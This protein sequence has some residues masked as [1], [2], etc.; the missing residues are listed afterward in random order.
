L[1][2]GLGRGASCGWRLRL[3]LL[4]LLLLRRLLLLLLLLLRLPLRLRLLLPPS[5]LVLLLA[6]GTKAAGPSIGTAAL[7]AAATA[8]PT[9]RLRSRSHSCNVLLDEILLLGHQHGGIGFR[10]GEEAMR[11]LTR[12]DR[13]AGHL[14]E[15]IA[16]RSSDMLAKVFEQHLR[17]I[18]GNELEL[19]HV[20]DVFRI[21]TITGIEPI[22]KKVQQM[23]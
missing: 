1:T 19:V 2:K 3:L 18:L 9:Q 8:A 13:Q 16:A 4:L 10:L 22:G 20:I 17:E 14:L 6:V 15:E 11:S 12:I 23:I 5:P 7:A 21:V